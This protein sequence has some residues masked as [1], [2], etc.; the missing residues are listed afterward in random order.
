MGSSA[1]GCAGLDEDNMHGNK[2]TRAVVATESAGQAVLRRGSTGS[3]APDE[4]RV[5]RMRLGAAGL[6]E[7]LE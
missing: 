7:K 5:M 2:R 4:E 1:P 3:L 6:V